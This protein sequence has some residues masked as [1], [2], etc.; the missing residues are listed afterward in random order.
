[1]SVPLLTRRDDR[2]RRRSFFPKNVYAE[3]SGA[4]EAK[5]RAQR[6]L[7]LHSAIAAVGILLLLSVVFHRLR[8]LLLVLVN[9][10]FALVGRRAG[11]L[12]EQFVRRGGPGRAHHRLAG[13]FRDPLRHYGAELDH[14]DFAFRASGEEEGM[15]WGWDAA[16]RGASERLMPVLDDGD[17]DRL[18]LAAARAG[19]GARPAAKSKADG[20]RHSRRPGHLHHVETA[21]LPTLALRYGRS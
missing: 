21:V 11:R 4:A 10:P 14:D 2:W 16:I 1:M 19:H 12:A 3:F 18:G 5:A 6:E 9:V 20:H 8:N 15:T 7:L 17:R 13:R